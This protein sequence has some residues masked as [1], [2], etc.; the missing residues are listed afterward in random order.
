MTLEAMQG[1][2][3]EP[4]IHPTVQVPILR[5]Q[6]DAV[7]QAKGEGREPVEMP[8]HCAE[9]G[10]LV[11]HLVSGTGEYVAADAAQLKLRQVLADVVGEILSREIDPEEYQ[12]GRN[13]QQ[14]PTQ[15]TLAHEVELTRVRVASTVPAAADF[16]AVNCFTEMPY[17]RCRVSSQRI[18]VSKPTPCICMRTDPSLS[19]WA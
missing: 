10:A 16:C 3:I 18:K 19:V 11:S 1:D 6:V 4:E 2:A 7:P 13:T 5:T 9:G 15:R 8:I 17:W 12:I 14:P